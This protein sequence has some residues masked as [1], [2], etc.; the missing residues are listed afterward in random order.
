MKK[1]EKNK[2]ER[3]KKKKTRKGNYK[4]F[5]NYEAFSNMKKLVGHLN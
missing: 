1:D 3:R 5:I 2:T 4:C